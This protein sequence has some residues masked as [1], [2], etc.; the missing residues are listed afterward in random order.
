MWHGKIKYLFNISVRDAEASLKYGAL[1]SRAANPPPQPASPQ[2][3]CTVTAQCTRTLTLTLT[4]TL[5]LTLTLKVPRLFPCTAA[6]QYW[7]AA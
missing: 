2:R 6:V 4:L 1:P 3:W 5:I 7:G